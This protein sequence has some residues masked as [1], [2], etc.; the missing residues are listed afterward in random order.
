LAFH[1][2][3]IDNN[4]NWS[5]VLI[6]TRNHD[7]DDVDGEYISFLERIQ[8]LWKASLPAKQLFTGALPLFR[9]HWSVDIIVIVIFGGGGG[10]TTGG[11]SGGE[12]DYKYYNIC[13]YCWCYYYYE[14]RWWQ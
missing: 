4:F 7:D 14:R 9:G 5:Y 2:Q 8:W 12:S 1:F 11:W 3:F 10:A 6:V 13:C